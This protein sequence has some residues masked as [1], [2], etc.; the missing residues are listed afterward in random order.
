METWTILFWH[1]RRKRMERMK[2]LNDFEWL[3]I[4][5]F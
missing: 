4:F 2:G 3:V 1:W 5:K